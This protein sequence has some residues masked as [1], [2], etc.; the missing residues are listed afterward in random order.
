MI[1]LALASLLVLAPQH[2]EPDVIVMKDGTEVECRVL[3]ESAERV[4]YRAKRK[5]REVAVSEVAEIHSIERSLSEFLDKTEALDLGQ[6][7]TCVALAELAEE[8]GLFGEARNMWIRILTI[9]PEHE[10]AWTKLGGVHSKRGWRLRVR[11]HWRNLAELRER[12]SA[13]KDAMELPT[14]HFLVRT[15][16]EPERAL[17]VTLDVERVYRAYYDAMGQAVEL[18]VFDEV[19]EIHIFSD[20]DDYPRPPRPGMGVWYARNPNELYID[21]SGEIS[22]QEVV[23]HMAYVMIFNSFRRTGGGRNGSITPWARE[24]LAQSFAWAFRPDPGRAKFEYG[25][26]ITPYFQSHARDEKPLSLSNVLGAGFGAF[27]GGTNEQRY[28][29]QS[30][31]LT[32]FLLNAGD[33]KYRTGFGEFLLSSFKGQGAGTHLKRALDVDLDD[34]EREWTAYVKQIAGA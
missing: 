8:R 34:L 14:A 16:I 22:R 30:Y 6:V 27:D 3:S 26:P 31:T 10:Q 21:A 29:A 9:D 17:A 1:Q 13:W 24:G 28:T 32:H 25:R 12:V 19:P 18:A 5:D 7:P 23:Q 2:D 4:K 20:A 33:G 15:N 11:G